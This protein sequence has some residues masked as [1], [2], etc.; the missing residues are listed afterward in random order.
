[1]RFSRL[2]S[3]DSR[4]PAAEADPNEVAVTMNDLTRQPATLQEVADAAG[5]HR[6]TASRA[7]NPEKA[8]LIGQDVVERVQ[9]A[10]AGSATSATCW[11]RGCA[12]SG[13]A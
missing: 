7:L 12:P 9:A 2:L 10:P 3:L 6:S 5:V 8:H 4:P 13:P 11:R 1:M